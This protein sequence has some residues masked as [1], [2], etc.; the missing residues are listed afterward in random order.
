MSTG[1]FAD[2]EDGYN[3]EE[4]VK[5][6]I[7]LAA[8]STPAL[9]VSTPTE[10]G[11]EDI[12]LNLD[13]VEAPEAAPSDDKPFDDTPFD[14]G[15]EADEDED[16][17]KYIQQLAGKLGTTL[18]KYT[19]DKGQPDFDLEKFAINSVIS[20]THTGEMD[21][22]DQKDIIKKIKNS[23]DKGKD[24]NVDVNVDTD[25][26]DDEDTNDVESETDDTDNSLDEAGDVNFDNGDKGFAPGVENQMWESDDLL[27]DAV[28]F[29]DFEVTEEENI[30][31]ELKNEM[32]FNDI[33]SMYE[34]AC[35]LLEMDSNEIDNILSNG[36]GWAL[37]HVSTST[38][39]VEH[40]Y[41]YFEGQE[42]MNEESESNN[43]MFFQNLKTLKHATYEILN[44]D[45]NMIDN[46]ISNHGE[47]ISNLAATAKD[48]I[49]EV[50]HFLTGQLGYDGDTEAGYEDEH[51]SVATPEDDMAQLFIASGINE[52]EY[53]GK[54]VKLG[55]PMKGDV[56]KFKVYVKNKKG[57][58]I[59]VNF[60]DPNMEI[61]RDNRER[62]KSFRARHK[63]SQAKDRTTPKYWS[64]KMW[65][66]TPVSKMVAE[67]KEKGVDGKACWKGYRYAGTENGKDKCVKVSE[68][69]TNINLN[70]NL[71][72]QIDKLA[73]II[74]ANPTKLEKAEELVS[75]VTDIDEDYK[76]S[77]YTNSLYTS[78]YHSSATAEDSY[79]EQ[80]YNRLIK[81]QATKRLI[82]GAAAIGLSFVPLMAA[83]SEVAKSLNVNVG[84]GANWFVAL[85]PILIAKIL[86]ITL[87]KVVQHAKRKSKEKW[88]DNWEKERIARK[89]E[90]KENENLKTDE[91]NS[92]FADNNYIIQKLR[93]ME[94]ANM[95]GPV[96]IPDNPIK[97]PVV[98]PETPIK[99]SP[100]RKRVWESEPVKSP[101]PKM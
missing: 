87:V 57:N 32:F 20:A 79:S 84:D 44:M 72:S 25:S 101:K 38:N 81:N 67:D 48:D 89:S 64:C 21:E 39:D 22:E 33:Y 70:E 10:T 97:E 50:Y 66:K 3:L 71:E 49:E 91:K 11:G 8:P 99:P 76:H 17:E 60:G 51:G 6:K 54:T 40:I 18:R 26:S 24:V 75:S 41:H 27:S 7:K 16:P 13:D 93:E 28:L 63:C 9:D 86:G 85:S 69:I 14:A 2:E 42:R 43:Y 5:Y 90:I 65:S 73:N 62:R 31:Q 4:E 95:L 46:E 74:S 96:T 55:K 35:E 59:K 52:A 45:V 37:D 80:V 58:V 34:D 23:G 92:I 56:K 68:S 82:L 19:E 61:K 36:H 94:D 77:D 78:Q 83:A 12:D 47:W 98:L 53:K 29:N 1:L 15:V 30:N 100:R 88:I